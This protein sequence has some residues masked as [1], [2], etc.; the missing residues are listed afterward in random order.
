MIEVSSQQV[1]VPL[2]PDDGLM[3]AGPSRSGPEELFA[4]RFG[5]VRYTDAMRKPADLRIRYARTAACEFP[6]CG[7]TGKYAEILVFDHCHAHGFVRGLLCTTHIARLGQIEAVAAIEGVTVDLG[8]TAYAKLVARCPGCS[9]S[10]VIEARGAFAPPLPE[11]LARQRA[12]EERAAAIAS[13]G[14]PVARPGAAA[15]H[16]PLDGG[17][18]A[19][20]RVTDAM[21]PA[22]GQLLCQKCSRATG[23]TMAP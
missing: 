5:H 20:G 22:D 14:A 19:C 18:T 21:V 10:P 8:T 9:G 17:R 6:G 13:A 4:A 12:R 1:G 2:G 16:V 23:R 7:L 3:V 11:W 15:A